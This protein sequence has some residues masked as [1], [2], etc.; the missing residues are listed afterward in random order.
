MTKLLAEHFHQLRVERGLNLAQLAGQVG[1]ANTTKG[2]NRLVTFERH[3][4]IHPKLLQ[5]LSVALGVSDEVVRTL[6]A[7]DERQF[8]GDWNCWAD[9]PVEPYTVVRL[10]PAVYKTVRVPAEI[11]SFVAGEVFAADLARQWNRKVCL[12]VSRRYSLWLDEQGLAYA[13]TEAVPGE[14]NAPYMALGRSRR[15]HLVR[16]L[17][18]D[19]FARSVQW[20]VRA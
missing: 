17:S 11:G 18:A 13:H 4:Q 5:K 12:V 15:T 10:L 19:D 14:P 8:L 2:I 7:E 3:G 20:P 16:S 6:A 9:V 1:Y